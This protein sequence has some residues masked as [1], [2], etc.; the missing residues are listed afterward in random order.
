MR[1]ML[2]A[3][4]RHVAQGRVA[5]DLLYVNNEEEGVLERFRNRHRGLARL[6][7]GRVYR[8]REDA[9]ADHRILGSQPERE[10]ASS[11]FE[12]CSI[13]RWTGQADV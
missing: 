13:W 3:L 11:D 10:Y 9:R 2:G 7:L 4:A 8:S 6:Y 5:V 12:D 1:R